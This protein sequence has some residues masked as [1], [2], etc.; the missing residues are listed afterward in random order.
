MGNNDAAEQLEVAKAEVRRL[1]AEVESLQA[2]VASLNEAYDV[3]T[4]TSIRLAAVGRV[5]PDS[6]GPVLRGWCC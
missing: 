3:A 2:E 6:G 5:D 4:N 1:E